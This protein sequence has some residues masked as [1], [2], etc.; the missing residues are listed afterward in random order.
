MRSRTSKASIALAMVGESI[1]RS[2]SSCSG[3]SV[4]RAVDTVLG[5]GTPFDDCTDRA[6]SLHFEQRSDLTED[7][8]FIKE[9]RNL[10]R[11][12]MENSGFVSYQYEWWHFDIGNIFWSR[13]TGQ[14]EAFGPLFGDEEWPA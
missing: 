9:R 13:K 10:L 14:P 12:A 6:H 1:F 11:S 4:V 2:I 5:M 8:E 3:V 7:E